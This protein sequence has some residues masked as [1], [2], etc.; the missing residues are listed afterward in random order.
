MAKQKV[1]PW[2]GKICNH[3]AV[4]GIETSVMDDGPGRGNRIAWVSTGTGLRFKVVIDRAMDIVD[5]F[6]NQHSLAWLSHGG[7]TAPQPHANSGIEWLYSFAGGLVTT[8]GLTHIGGPNEDAPMNRGLHDRCS[9]LRASVESI[10]QPDP[11]SGKLE[12][13]ITGLVKHSMLFGPNLEMRR[14][15]ACTLGTPVIR[16]RDVVTNR[17]NL[18]CPH[19]LLYH[20]NFGWP[21]VDAGADIVYKGACKSFG[22]DI[23]DAV[24]NAN[25]NYRKCSA[26]LESHRGFGEG[27]GVIDV[28]PDAKGLCAAGICNPRIG[29]GVRVLWNKRQLP[30]L[31]NWQ[32]WGFGEYIT[33]LEPGTN[34]PIGQNTAREQKKLIM[35]APG[36]SRTYDLQIAVLSEEKE[37]RKFL[38]SAGE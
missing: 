5:A 38:Q 7:I 26:P 34:P 25:R 18:P 14:T 10:I 17:G 32:H 9:N 20:C 21:L 30:A 6:Y 33:G 24:F 28:K 23:D 27:C 1:L 31:T 2:E 12:M 16:I 4:G 36:K 3:A 15:I 11:A 22:R 37:I 8:C 19:M 13:S 29:L 35:L